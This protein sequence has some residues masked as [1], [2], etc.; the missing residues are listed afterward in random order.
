LSFDFLS[1]HCRRVPF[2]LAVCL[3]C[4][5]VGVVALLIQLVVLHA[6]KVRIEEF[7]FFYGESLATFDL[8]NLQLHIG[9]IPLGCY[10]KYDIHQ[11]SLLPTIARVGHLLLPLVILLGLGMLL[12]GPEAGWHQFVTGFRQMVVGLLHPQDVGYALIG[13]L[14]ALY[15]Q[16][17]VEMAG[18]LCMKGVAWSLLPIGNVGGAILHQIFSPSVRPREG[19]ERVITMAMMVGFFATMVWIGI[20]L[21]YAVKHWA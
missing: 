9:W 20:F 15:K 16:S 8:G 21:V 10:G 3:I 12:L 13:K 2:P 1:A 17:P 19:I 14:H 11:F 6:Y 5:S 4:F 7:H 18:V